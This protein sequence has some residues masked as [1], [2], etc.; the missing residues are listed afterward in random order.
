[1]TQHFEGNLAAYTIGKLFRRREYI[2]RAVPRDS[3]E[4]KQRRAQARHRARVHKTAH[5]RG[6][7]I[8]NTSH[9]T[10]E[11]RHAR[12]ESLRSLGTSYAAIATIMNFDF[13]DQELTAEDVRRMLSSHNSRPT[14]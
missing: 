9:T 12:M 2:A 7:L 11:F 14:G 10:P 6:R 1:M 5:T 8:T 3:V 13:R 4:A